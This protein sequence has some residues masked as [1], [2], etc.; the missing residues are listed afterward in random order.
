MRSFFTG[1]KVRFITAS[2]R[3]CLLLFNSSLPWQILLPWYCYYA[4]CRCVYKASGAVYSR[5]SFHRRGICILP[6][7]CQSSFQGALHSVNRY[8]GPLLPDDGTGYVALSRAHHPLLASFI[9]ESLSFWRQEVE[10]IFGSH[11][12]CHW[13]S[14]YRTYP[15]SN[16]DTSSS[17]A[18]HYDEDPPA[19][20]K[21]F[22]Y[23][24]DTTRRNGAFRCFPKSMSRELFGRGFISNSKSLRAQSQGLIDSAVLANS[25][26][27]EGEAGTAFLFDNNIIHRGT[28]PESGYRTVISVEV[29]PSDRPLHHRN[30]QNGLMLPILS[31]YPHLPWKNPYLV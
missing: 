28:H 20:K 10:A 15:F 29:M 6:S 4:Y 7:L 11:F 16:P 5:H 23:L 18:W 24:D 13:I 2:D 31:D 14:V 17:F 25:C 12:S 19:L 9:Y 22:I 30:I 21:I 8:L 27:I 1:L 3:L 26:W